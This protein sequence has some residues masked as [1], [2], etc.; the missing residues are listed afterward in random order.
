MHARAPFLPAMTARVWWFC[1]RSATPLQQEASHAPHCA[2]LPHR[3]RLSG[4][5]SD[6]KHVSRLSARYSLLATCYQRTGNLEL[7]V[8]YASKSMFG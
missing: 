4:Q 3:G 8:S 1:I 7:A 6:E 2:F 5:G